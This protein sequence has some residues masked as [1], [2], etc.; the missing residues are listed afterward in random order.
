MNIDVVLAHYAQTGVSMLEPCKQSNVPL[1][2]HCHGYDV[3]STNVLKKWGNR[4]EDIG[5][6]AYAI[7]VVS[8]KMMTEIDPFNA[9]KVSEDS[10]NDRQL[11][12][13]TEVQ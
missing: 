9:D 5:K 8:E 13:E 12:N 1:V 3:H 4:Y 10:G 11:L 2:V 7:I 6:Y